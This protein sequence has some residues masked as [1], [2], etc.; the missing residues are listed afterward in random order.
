M[1]PDKEP[2]KE[3]VVTEKKI[4]SAKYEKA[5]L[6]HFDQQCKD[7][8]NQLNEQLKALGE[9]TE[10][11]VAVLAE[12]EDF[13]KKRGEVEAEHAKNLEKLARGIIQRQK[14]EKIK[15]DA[16]THHASCSVWQELVDSTRSEAEERQGMANLLIKKIA[17]GVAMRADDLQR[18]SK[19]CRDIAILAHSEMHRVMTELQTAMKTYQI[20]YGECSMA[21]K[22]MRSAQDE[23]AKTDNANAGKSTLSRK[24]KQC[25]KVLTKRAEKYRGVRLRCTKARNEYILCVKAA[26]ASLHKFYAD[27]LSFLIDC[28]DL[29]MDFWLQSLIGTVSES[30]KD[31]AMKEMTSLADLEGL[32]DSLDSRAD[33]QSFFESRPTVFMLPKPFEFM[34]QMGDTEGEVVAEDGLGLELGQ[35]H[36]QIEKRLDG[37]RFE[38]DEVW[39]SLEASEKQLLSL[40]SNQDEDTTKWRNDLAVT[41]QY[42]LKKMEYFML[43]GNLIERL[44][45]RSKVI[46]SALG[47]S[48]N[49]LST[50]VDHTRAKRRTRRIA[51]SINGK[52]TPKLFG[53]SLEEYCEMTGDEVP[54]IVTSTIGYLSRFALRHQGLFR[55]SGSTSEIN[56]F[57]EAFERGEDTVSDLI[58]PSEINSVAGV[59]KLY[60]RE[61]RE[62]PFP[63]Y[64]FDQFTACVMNAERD[65]KVFVQRVHDLICRLPPSSIRLLRFLF[66][67]L[68]HLCEFS[69]ENMMEPHNVAICLGPTLLPIPEGKD[70]V[71]YHNF[72]NELIR[73]MII[74]HESVFP[75]IDALPGIVYDKYKVAR[76]EPFSYAED[77]EGEEDTGDEEESTTSIMEERTPRCSTD[78]STRYSSM[79]S[80]RPLVISPSPSSAHRSMMMGG[81]GLGRGGGPSSSSPSPSPLLATHTDTSHSSCGS[82]TRIA[83][84]GM[85]REERVGGGDRMDKREERGENTVWEM[86]PSSSGHPVPIFTSLRGQLHHLR[87][88]DEPKLDAR[89]S[90]L[91]NNAPSP[92]PPLPPLP[93]LI[94][95]PSALPPKSTELSSELNKLFRENGTRDG[96]Q[97]DVVL[98]SV[99]RSSP[100]LPSLSH[101]SPSPLSAPSLSPGIC[102]DELSAMLATLKE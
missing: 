62:P 43:N 89:M 2:E 76:E 31:L 80:P 42:Y 34:A 35:R 92:I 90:F 24:Q 63:L 99:R 70:Q 17:P 52:P 16:W 46:V 58:D 69:D 65:E 29:G 3:K 59:L 36:T 49:H 98:Q 28:A 78:Y 13:V 26:N 60:L 19:K 18:M 41:F 55:V 88:D 77:G 10:T 101:P 94:S 50:L 5:V 23:L 68:S 93:P 100:S 86:T 79:A 20:V 1:S 6:H 85:T 75:S 81:G 102:I 66:A 97:P 53:S 95:R 30:R 21:E 45:T 57:K 56:K 96:H 11:Q 8:R 83:L 33:K 9:R 51:P 37:L 84:P 39:K 25:Q 14:T 32:R 12:L 54:L 74:H 87:R 40:Y 67:F 44:Q 4:S 82:V 15:R 38:S 48:T 64:L 7:I 27:D 91:N 72:V 47:G 71:F 73:G 61:L 22:K